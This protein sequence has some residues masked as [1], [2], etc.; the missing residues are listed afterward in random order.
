MRRNG[1]RAIF[2]PLPINKRFA[3][4]TLPPVG[5]F[6]RPEWWYTHRYTAHARLL[7]HE[8]AHWDQYRQ[9]GAIRY[10]WDYLTLAARHGYKDHPM[11]IEARERSHG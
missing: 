7:R 6:I 10:Y 9:R 4:I 1:I 3:A 11:E 2:G 5:I 8:L